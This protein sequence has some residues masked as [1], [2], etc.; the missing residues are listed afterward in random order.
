MLSTMIMLAAE[1]HEY[2]LDK[3]G[4]PYILHPL[5]VMNI[6]ASDDEELNCIAVGHD[7]IEDTE[8]DGAK[9]RRYGMSKRVIAGIECLTKWP[10]QTYE[11]YQEAVM[12]NVDAIRVKMADLT[13]NSDIRRLKG[14]TEKDIACMAKYAEFYTLLKEALQKIEANV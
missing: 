4:K 2:Q 10:G 13:H 1:A 8:V 12:S 3:G 6:L 7:L 5:A 11:E 9:L 14:V